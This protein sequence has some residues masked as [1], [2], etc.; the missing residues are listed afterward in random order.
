MSARAA[1]DRIRR[2]GDEPRFVPIDQYHPMPVMRAG[3]PG[4]SSDLALPQPE[5]NGSRTII[6]GESD[7]SPYGHLGPDSTP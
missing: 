3:R 1:E 4:A 7:G 6:S 2:I 5:A